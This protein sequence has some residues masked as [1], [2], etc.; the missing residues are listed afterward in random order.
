MPTENSLDLWNQKEVLVAIIGLASGVI[1]LWSGLAGK[2]ADKFLTSSDTRVADNAAERGQLWKRIDGLEKE[3]RLQGERF[4][5][6]A[7]EYER[8][9]KELQD[10]LDEW[11]EKYYKLISEYSDLKAEN[12]LIRA[13]NHKLVSSLAALKLT[14]QRLQRQ[15]GVPEALPG[16]TSGMPGEVGVEL[17][18]LR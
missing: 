9:Q 16:P 3:M 6:R 17:D 11:R 15:V 12:L 10:E 1:A 14:L 2:L 4:D 18:D 8:A 7:T 13:E 5:R